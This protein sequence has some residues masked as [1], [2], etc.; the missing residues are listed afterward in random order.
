MS[1]ADFL[2]QGETLYSFD[3]FLSAD[4]ESIETVI[5]RDKENTKSCSKLSYSWTGPDTKSVYSVI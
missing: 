2:S 5:C 3:F 4:H 1:N